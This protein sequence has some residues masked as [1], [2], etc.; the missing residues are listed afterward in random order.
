MRGVIA[1][2]LYAPQDAPALEVLK[3]LFPQRE[4]VGLLRRDNLLR[5]RQHPLYYTTT[6]ATGKEFLAGALNIA[7]QET[8]L[9][10]G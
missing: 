2:N 8:R 5:R 9:E 3:R 6:A 10:N 4:V 7:N 1:P